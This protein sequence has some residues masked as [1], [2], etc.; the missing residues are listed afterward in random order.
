MEIIKDVNCTKDTP[1]I[2][3]HLDAPIYGSGMCVQPL[4]PGKTKL[5][6]RRKAFFLN[7]YLLNLIVVL[8]SG[9]KDS[10]AAYFRLLELGVP[11]EKIELW[12][13]DIDGGHPTRRRDWPVTPA[14]VKSFAQAEGV[15]L[16][17]SW[18]VNGFWGEV[19]WLGAFGGSE[20][21]PC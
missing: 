20:G 8:F 1:V 9:G 5:S 2:Y 6:M 4:V 19:Y 14:Y 3:G 13:H 12:H 16:R 10:T 11:K 21:G 7:C 15:R 17:V 18:R